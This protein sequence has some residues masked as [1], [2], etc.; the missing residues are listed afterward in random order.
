M[1]TSTAPISKG[2]LWTSYV[3]SGLPV[4]MLTVSG[5]MKFVQPAGMD[6]EFARLGWPIEKAVTLGAIELACTLLYAIPRT[7]VL[8]A[9]LLAGYLGGA[10]ATHLRF[11]DLWYMPLAVG[12][13]LW[14]GL[15]L[16]EPRLKAL[17]PLRS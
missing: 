11:G 3:L 14:L 2:L 5:V 8:G 10:V 12:I 16:R 13:V 4:L 9:I 6:A 17:L 15:W 1:S 7:A